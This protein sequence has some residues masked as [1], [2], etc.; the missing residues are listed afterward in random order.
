MIKLPLIFVFL[1]GA[2]HCF[3]QNYHLEKDT[4]RT[5]GWLYIVTMPNRQQIEMSSMY[6]INPNDII[7]ISVQKDSTILKSYGLKA[8]NGLVNVKLKKDVNF[9]NL[10]QLL[11]KFRIPANDKY[12][13]VAIDSVIYNHPD[14]IYFRPEQIKRIKFVRID[15]EKETGMKFINIRTMLP[16]DRNTVYIR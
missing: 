2:L 14:M 15:I 12:L 6:G 5:K 4:S 13:P 10:N 16:I 8:M 1:F 9:F 7:S 11:S 3:G